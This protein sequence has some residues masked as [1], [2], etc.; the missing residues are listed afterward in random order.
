MIADLWWQSKT[1]Q[2]K[3]AKYWYL[4]CAHNMEVHAQVFAYYIMCFIDPYPELY[5]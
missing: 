5:D 3:V 4:L 2:I 1:W